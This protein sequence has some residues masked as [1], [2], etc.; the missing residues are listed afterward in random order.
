MTVPVTA[1]M[2]FFL[3]GSLT[4][5]SGGVTIPVAAGKQRAVLAALLLDAGRVVPVDELAGALWGEA[6]P[7]SARVTVQTYVMRLRKTLGPA[8][9][10]R[11]E[12]RPGGYLISVDTAELD[13]TR[14]E[15]LIR[16]ARAAA[17]NGC[18]EAAAAR[19]REALVLWRGEPLADAGSD[20]LGLREA[21]RLAELRLQALEA[22]A[23]ADLHLGQ[24]AEVIAELG[25]LVAANPL[26][27]RLRALLM[28]ALYRSGR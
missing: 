23:E 21:P 7:A 28:L 8:G 2:E 3:L 22:R 10:D 24:H 4:V 5:R 26:R 14:F 15:A 25:D 9:R 1:A 13:V 16:A 11:I 19:A 27:E 12:T 17:R 20:V 6:P 18:W